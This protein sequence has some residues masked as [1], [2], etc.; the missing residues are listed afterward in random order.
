MKIY[1]AI[2]ILGGKAVRL[3]QGRKDDATTYGDPVEMA[4][5][6]VAQGAK[7]DTGHRREHHTAVA[8]VEVYEL[9][10]LAFGL[11]QQHILAGDPDVGRPRFDVR[12]RERDC[13]P[14]PFGCGNPLGQPV[15]EFA[16]ERHDARKV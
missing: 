10:H 14:A 8:V 7:D 1:P 16:G 13:R 4:S 15:L 12:R 6:W 2:D 5:K 3:K 9:V 11:L